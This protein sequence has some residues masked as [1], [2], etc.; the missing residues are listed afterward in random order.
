MDREI[1]KDKGVS[2]NED[3]KES[4]SSAL[5]VQQGL[6]QKERHFERLFKEH[7]IFYLPQNII[8][9]DFYWTGARHNLKYL[10]VGDCT[11]HGIPA[12]LLSVLAL[13]LFE[14]II[15]NQRIKKTNK[16][17]R[18]LDARFIDSFKYYSEKGV[19]DN[20]WIDLSIICIDEYEHKV[21]FS[22]ANRKMLYVNSEKKA[23]IYK[24]S[25]YPIGGWQIEEHRKFEA[26]AIN[27]EE[28]DKIYLGT[29]GFQD[30]LGG[31]KEKKYK[32]KKLHEMI[33]L[34]SHLPFIKQKQELEKEFLNWKE[35]YTQTDD[36]CIVGIML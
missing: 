1:L 25:R 15:M 29:D 12:A 35:A 19:F 31:T 11:G 26:I 28:G 10:V 8:S 2:K 9:G 24:G 27:Y 33:R 21:Y 5:I 30:Q 23:K 36:V 17:L 7:F 32:A 18:E 13:N 3:C 20:P 34:N 4:L 14:N 22:S 6:L 16:I